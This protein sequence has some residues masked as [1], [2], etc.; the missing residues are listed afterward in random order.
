[1]ARPK[2]TILLNREIDPQHSIEILQAEQLW[3][4]VYQGQPINIRKVVWIVS[5]T[6]FKYLRHGFPKE[7]PAK[8]LA[9]KLNRWF[10]TDQF[11]HKRVL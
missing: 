8:N 2:P 9:E 1:M 7:A 5:G 11:T 6:S 4:V 10:F 3:T